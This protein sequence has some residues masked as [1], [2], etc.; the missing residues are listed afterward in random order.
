MPYTDIDTVRLVLA[1]DGDPDGTAASLSDETINEAI[2]RVGN[3][4]DTFLARRYT[5]PIPAPIPAILKDLATDIA[6][7][8]LTLAYYKST[9]ITDQDPVIRRYR[10]ARGMLGQLSTGLLILDL[11]GDE[12]IDDPVVINPPE[13]RPCSPGPG[14]EVK[15][16]REYGPW[17]YR[18][19]S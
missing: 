5:L 16:I 15:V 10:D 19:G 4:V 8:D 18:Y 2:E 11:P 6:A 9:D 14:F 3:R 1:P 17:E 7:Y 13:Y 12:T